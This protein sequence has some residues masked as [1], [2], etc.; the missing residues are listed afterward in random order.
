MVCA[1]AM[2]LANFGLELWLGKSFANEASTVARIILLGVWV[3]GL[4]FVP[5]TLLQSQ[6]RPDLPAKLHVMELVPFIAV[7]WFCLHT[8]G[9]AGAAI[10]W[11]ARVVTDAA[12]MFWGAG[13]S[14]SLLKKLATTVLTVVTTFGLSV[15]LPENIVTDATL[16]VCVFASILVLAYSRDAT[17]KQLCRQMAFAQPSR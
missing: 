11:T 6:G 1:P 7:L 10:A 14:L 4:A 13:F 2:F 9:L 15:A 16:A 12:L 3:N 17:I 5:F 8:F